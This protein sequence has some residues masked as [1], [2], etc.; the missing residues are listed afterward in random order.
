MEQNRTEH[1]VTNPSSYSHLIFDFK[2]LQMGLG[3]L[4]IHLQK[5]ETRFQSL[6]YTSINS[7]WIKGH[8]I[9]YQTTTGNNREYTGTNCS[10]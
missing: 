2:N 3:N 7:K 10:R 8:T 9:R 4:D 5:T 1:P 6:T